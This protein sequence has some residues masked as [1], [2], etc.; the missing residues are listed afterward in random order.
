MRR[1]LPTV[2]SV[3]LTSTLIAAS[4]QLKPIQSD[5]N[6]ID[7]KSSLVY[8]TVAEGNLSVDLYFPDAWRATDHRPAIILFFG[9]GF[10]SG[11]TNQ[12]GGTAKYFASRGLVAATPDYR[13]RGRQQTGPEKSIED[14]RSAIRWIRMNA[15]RLG[16]DPQRIIAGG[17]SSGGTGVVLAAYSSAYQPEADDQTISDRPN[18]LLLYNPALGFGSHGGE[19]PPEVVKALEP[20]IS[21]WKVTSGGPPA[22]VFFG[23][24]DNLI[25]RGR[26]FAEQMIAVGN[27]AE[28]YT[29]EGQGHGFFQELRPIGH[30]HEAVVHQS[31]LFLASLG[32]LHG[33]PTIERPVAEVLKKVL[34]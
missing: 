33:E 3:A 32:Y 28:L 19:V 29:A 34:P 14:M 12:F 25:E 6:P 31:D 7:S 4:T 9:G 21:N 17:A 16:I 26:A 30:W 20:V 1:V 5:V 10:G 2:A 11:T 8:K 22:I 27:R 23:T 24:E 18:A 15:A 13:V